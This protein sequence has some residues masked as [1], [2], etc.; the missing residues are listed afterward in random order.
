MRE[1]RSPRL[2]VCLALLMALTGPVWAQ[3]KPAATKPADAEKGAKLAITVKEV[4]GRVQKMVTEDGKKTWAP[5]KAGEA[6]DEMTVIRTGFRSKVVLQFSDNSVVEVHRATKMGVAE[7][8]KKGKVVKTRLG[9]K[10]GSMRTTVERARGPNDFTVATPVATMAVTGSNPSQGF[11]GDFGYNAHMPHGNAVVT[12]GGKQRT[13]GNRMGTNNRLAQWSVMAQKGVKPILVGGAGSQ[14]LSPSEVK[15]MAAQGGG[16]GGLG[17]GT[18]TGSLGSKVL[19]NSQQQSLTAG[20]IARKNERQRLLILR[21]LRLRQLYL[22][23]LAQTG[24]DDK[25]DENGDCIIVGD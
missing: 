24:G 4:A 13:L 12:M 16:R 9:L 15:F 14:D 2:V 5:L 25:G 1:H 20:I 23:Q 6:V 18:P 11:T 17:G 10:Y 3:S 22:L 8:R 7:F 21:Q 19:G